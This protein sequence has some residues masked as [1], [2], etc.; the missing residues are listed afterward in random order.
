MANME[1]RGPGRELPNIT[2]FQIF[3]ELSQA[4]VKAFSEMEDGIEIP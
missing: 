2:H 3:I 1:T 4:R